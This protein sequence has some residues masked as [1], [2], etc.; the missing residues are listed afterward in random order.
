[1]K[2]YHYILAFFNVLFWIAVPF[3]LGNGIL[4]LIGS[5]IT[6]DWD[7]MNWWILN[8]VW[9]RIILVVM[10]LVL[11]VNVPNFWEEIMNS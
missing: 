1:M 2:F 3:L 11:L 10:E 4:Y 6:W 9:G 7:P 5:F 8:T